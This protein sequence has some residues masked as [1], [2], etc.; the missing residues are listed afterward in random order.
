[1][2]ALEPISV[3][4]SVSHLLLNPPLDMYFSISFVFTRTS[5]CSPFLPPP[6]ATPRPD[7]LGYANFAYY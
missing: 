7:V 5:E 3:G 1:M 2:R 4:H 6:L